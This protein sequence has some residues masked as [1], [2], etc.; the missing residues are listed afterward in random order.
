MLAEKLRLR[1]YLQ[2]P[3]PQRTKETPPAGGIP[4]GLP[5][6]KAKASA[7]TAAALPVGIPA[8]DGETC[9]CPALWRVTRPSLSLEVTLCSAMLLLVCPVCPVSGICPALLA[10]CLS[11]LCLGLALW[12][13]LLP[14]LLLVSAGAVLRVPALVSC[15]VSGLMS[16]PFRR[17]KISPAG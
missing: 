11:L 10:V 4:A 17:Y 5:P 12:C 6:G 7:A 9:G 1:G 15:P 13:C 16:F 3:A 2:R 8:G 14:V